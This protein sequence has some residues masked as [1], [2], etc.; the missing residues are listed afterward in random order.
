MECQTMNAAQSKALIATAR[1]ALA[2]LDPDWPQA[3]ALKQAITDAQAPST[4]ARRSK[5]KRYYGPDVWRDGRCLDDD[6]ARK[7]A[8]SVH[9]R[10]RHGWG[11]GLTNAE[12][13]QMDKAY[14]AEMARRQKER[15]RLSYCACGGKAED[16][17]EDKD[18]NLLECSHCDGCDHFHYQT[19]SAEAA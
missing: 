1:K 15:E 2:L 19:D 6:D 11:K 4:N 9:F 8:E 7:F 12:R 18:G 3:Q 14:K 5:A 17:R 16:H 13:K 10:F